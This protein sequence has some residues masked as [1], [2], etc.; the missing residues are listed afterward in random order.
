MQL[1]YRK[2]G[3]TTRREFIGMCFSQWEVKWQAMLINRMDT[4]STKN[5]T[6][7]L[8]EFSEFHPRIESS[9]RLETSS[10]NPDTDVL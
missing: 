1:C 6:G 7:T 4:K 2:L 9:G 3:D 8:L 10:P 5:Y